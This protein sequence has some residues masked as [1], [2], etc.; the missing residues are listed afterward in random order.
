MLYGKSRIRARGV[1]GLSAKGQDMKLLS[2][3]VATMVLLLAFVATSSGEKPGVQHDNRRRLEYTT[4]SDTYA[5]F[6]LEEILPEVSKNYNLI[7][8]AAGRGICGSSAGGICSFTVAWER[9]DAF[10]KVIS[11]IGGY[12]GVPGGG[13][14]PTMIRKTRENPKPIRVFLEDTENDLNT[15]LGDFTLGNLQMESALKFARYDY[16]F[17]TGSGGHDL[18]YGGSILP[19][20]LRWLWRDYPG[21]KGTDE[22]AIKGKKVSGKSMGKTKADYQGKKAK[23]GAYLKQVWAKLQAEVEAGNM[24]EEDAKAKMIA[25]KK[26]VTVK[27][28]SNV[29]ADS[30]DGEN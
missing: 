17:E 13:D 27:M 26:D 23:T 28:K 12:V 24:S 19:D 4:L 21:V 15:S 25:I 14:Y 10:S 11:L 20:M 30:S 8:D 9:P 7:S 5:R 16:R 29:S 1:A 22:S 2:T 3:I 18:E 6:L